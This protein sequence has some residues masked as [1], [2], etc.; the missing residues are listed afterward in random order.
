MF[1]MTISRRQLLI[2]G[3]ASGAALLGA[4]NNIPSSL[5]YPPEPLI[6]TPDDPS[7]SHYRCPEWFRDAKFGIWS[8]WGPE[9]VPEQG[10]W[11]A[12]Y[13]YMQGNPDYEYHLQHYGH[14]SKAG[15]KDIIPLWKA[16]NWNPDKLMARYKNSGA[17]YFCMI[18]EH[19]DNFDCWNS[20]YQ[21]WNSVNMGP[22]RDIAAEWQ[23]AAKKH[24]LHFG[25]TE[26]LAASWWFYS[27]AKG[28]DTTGP[29]ADVPYDGADPAYADLYWKGNEHPNGV[30]YIPD[31]PEFVKETW[32]KRI[33]DMVDRY[34][35]DL[36]YSDSPLPYPD[37]YGRKLLAHFYN[38]NIRKHQGKLEAVYTCKQDSLSKWVQD[39][40][41]GVMADINPLPW[42]SETCVGDWYYRKSLLEN[43]EYKSAETIIHMLTDI[44]SKNGNFL[45]NFPLRPDGALDSDELKILDELG[46][47][48]AVN[49]EAIYGTRPWMIFG[50]SAFKINS[51][52]F[53]ESG[54]RYSARDIRFTSKGG[55]LYAIALG[56]PE[57]NQ[58]VIRSLPKDAGKIRDIR[59]LGYDGRLKWMQN[60]GGLTI[61]LPNKKPCKF[62]YAFHITPSDLHP[63]KTATTSIIP[64]DSSGV[65]ALPAKMAVI[66]GAT[67]RYEYGA[68]KD[69]IGFWSNPD[70]YIS[71]E[72]EVK[73]PGLYDL[74][75]S[76]SCDPSAA[77]SFYQVEAAGQSFT[78]KSKSTGS[79]SFFHSEYLR[80]IAFDNSGKYE[81][82][83][84]PVTPP[85]WKVIGL[86]SVTL[87]PIK[88]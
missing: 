47:W 54:L 2:K 64:Q 16:E 80:Q 29:L 52:A 57:D 58:I 14:P 8:V 21:R 34:H 74:N 85:Q 61:S 78:G 15:Y 53:N 51:G 76:Y 37:K 4:A 66:H 23:K 25:M 35:P 20:R 31:A 24:G 75:I 18:A 83:I 43:H 49:E 63:V 30:Y 67:P 50:E 46:E 77:G 10:D 41:R 84:K 70:D 5:A 60:G 48:F 82:T 81:L 68:G 22:K 71:W 13:M 7:L 40:E 44:V 73:T 42:Q 28:S 3:A 36:L 11:F 6:F 27:A 9:C 1:T 69:D 26:H 33:K 32:Y 65:I 88:K 62:A 86:H 56:W 55:A 72:F 59:L 19:H 12:H 45:L 39:L 17:K 79:W 38:D 87:T